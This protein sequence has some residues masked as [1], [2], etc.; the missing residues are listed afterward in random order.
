MKRYVCING[1]LLE[2]EKAKISVYDRGLIYGDGFFTTMRSEKGKIFFFEEHLERL[3][4]CCDCFKIRFP[5]RLN[6]KEI[7]RKLISLNGLEDSVA[8]VKVMITR[9]SLKEEKGLPYGETPTWIIFAKRYHIPEEKYNEGFYLVPFKLKRSTPLAFYKSLN[10]LYNMWAKDYAV[11]LGA[12]DS[13]LIGYDGYVKETSTGA[14]IFR[15]DGLWFTPYGDDILPSI[16]LKMLRRVWS[17]RG[18]KI[19]EKNVTVEELKESEQ[20]FVLNSLIGVMPVRRIEERVFK[21]DLVF[22]EK[23]RNWLWEYAR[24]LS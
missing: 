23:S 20:I 6:E 22:A 3:K 7:F 11:N 5:E 16:T 18:I 24:S 13:I 17:E 19:K 4:Y 8:A 15:K 2:A 10:Y 14:I 1:E 21:K 12:D 9:G